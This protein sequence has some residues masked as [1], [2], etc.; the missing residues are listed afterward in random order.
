MKPQSRSK[1]TSLLMLMPIVFALSVVMPE[2]AHAKGEKKAAKAVRKAA[3]KQAGTIRREGRAMARE[4][5]NDGKEAKANDASEAASI[6]I[7][8][9]E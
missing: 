8:A 3:R 4:I 2:V 5:I 7:Q 6:A 1:M 9:I